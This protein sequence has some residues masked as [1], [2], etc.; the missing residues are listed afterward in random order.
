M[1]NT[2]HIELYL[3]GEL[4]GNDLTEFELRLQTDPSFKSEVE[5]HRDV[6]N[7]ILNIPKEEKFRILT[8]EVYREYIKQNEIQKKSFLFKN[9]RS[10]AASVVFLVCGSVLTYFL[11]PVSNKSLFDQNFEH[12]SID[13]NTR[14]A[15][16]PETVY[17]NAVELYQE[18]KYPEAIIAFSKIKEE[19]TSNNYIPFICGL[20]CLEINKVNDAIQFLSY[21]CKDKKNALYGQSSWYLALAYIKNNENEKAIVILKK[22]KNEHLFNEDK[23]EKLLNKLE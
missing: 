17:D 7:Y 15:N 18:K 16:S 14:S 9:W 2:E 4:N 1:N 10:V 23:A 12:Y 5:T 3:K 8:N 19:T 22:I 13:N 11:I 21:S 20:S 6:N